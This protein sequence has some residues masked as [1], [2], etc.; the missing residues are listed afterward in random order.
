MMER[1]A[2][3]CV[4]LN[5]ARHH[6]RVPSFIVVRAVLRDGQLP[7]VIRSLTM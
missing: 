2:L 5:G 6:Q 1:H 7:L 4:D 3:V